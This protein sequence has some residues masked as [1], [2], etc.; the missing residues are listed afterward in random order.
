MFV[1][2]KHYKHTKAKEEM[3]D[4]QIIGYKRANPRPNAP[5]PTIKTFDRFSRTTPRLDWA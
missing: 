4:D 2:R 3:K 5:F 1:E